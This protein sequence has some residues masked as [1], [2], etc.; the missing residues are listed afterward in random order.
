MGDEIRVPK[1]HPNGELMGY[2]V[3]DRKTGYVITFQNP[4]IK[5]AEKFFME[6][7]AA[8]PGGQEMLDEYVKQR[9]ESETGKRLKSIE[10]QL[11][12]VPV[13]D[14]LDIKQAAEYLVISVSALRRRIKDGSIP[15]AKVGGAF[16][17]WRSDVD[18][19]LD[20]LKRAAPRAARHTPP[21]KTAKKPDP[22]KILRT[23]GLGRN[24]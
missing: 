15:A 7:T 6:R 9:T 13:K 8:M 20:G 14:R 16:Q 24:R 23:M 4:H 2:E 3:I 10:D 12:A 11:R 22:A 1:Y 21:G 18:A 5:E 17:I 19:Y